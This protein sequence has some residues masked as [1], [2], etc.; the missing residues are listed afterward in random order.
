[1]LITEIITNLE[2]G[3]FDEQLRMLN[4]QEDIADQKVRYRELLEAFKMRFG[5]QDAHLICTPGRT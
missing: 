4:C 3:I 2:K 5:D 1:M